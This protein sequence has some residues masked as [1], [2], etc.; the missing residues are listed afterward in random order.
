MATTN[1]RAGGRVISL[2]TWR[3]R[4]TIFKRWTNAAI[5]FV[6]I[7]HANSTPS[8]TIH[9]ARRYLNDEWR[10]SQPTQTPHLPLTLP[11]PLAFLPTAFFS[12]LRSPA[13]AVH[14][15]TSLLE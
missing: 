1:V 7:A 4:D 15:P 12:D 14:E 10:S 9:A 8:S 5:Q 13:S 11:L 3:P 6:T 2:V